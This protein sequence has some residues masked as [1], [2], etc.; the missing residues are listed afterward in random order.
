MIIKGIILKLNKKSALVT[1]GFTSL[2]GKEGAVDI[3]N[4]G[5]KAF[6]SLNVIHQWFLHHDYIT[7]WCGS[8]AHFIYGPFSFEENIPQGQRCSCAC[9]CE[10]LQQQVILA[11]Q[12]R[13][14]LETTVFIQEGA[15]SHIARQALLCAHFGD[16]VILRSFPIAWLPCSPDLNLYDLWLW[17]FLKDR[18][19]GGNI[20]TML[21]LKASITHHIAA[22]D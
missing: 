19:Y 16:Q 4:C 9:Y 2:I 17:R 15:P 20:W 21:K 1:G 22:N 5:I 7:V 18:A 8:T 11:L 6:A 10:L 12:E 13:E 3:Q 14:Y